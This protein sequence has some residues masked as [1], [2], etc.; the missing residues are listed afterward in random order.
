LKELGIQ[1]SF[2]IRGK[3]TKEKKQQTRELQKM[4]NRMEG[5]IGTLKERWDL[6]KIT[7]SIK[8]GAAIQNY[9][10]LGI[11]NLAKAASSMT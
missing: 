8:D 9:V 3:P 2:A 11:H 7:Y 10:C 1:H 5:I 4:R 6:K